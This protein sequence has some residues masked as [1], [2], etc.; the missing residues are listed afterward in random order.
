MEIVG[1]IVIVILLIIIGYYQNHKIGS[2]EAQIKSQKGILESA[3]TF[4]K[5]FDLEKLKGYGEI[6]AEK[7][8]VEKE[9]ELKKINEDFEE[10]IK[11][12]KD[13]SKFLEGEFLLLIRAFLEAF[14]YLPSNFREK[15]I[16][17][18]GV[19]SY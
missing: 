18:M 13:A 11:R 17:H 6:L 19:R 1:D 14:S 12:H 15:V 9:I 5:L 16:N 7:V 8:K 4:L 10:K 2:L 3:D